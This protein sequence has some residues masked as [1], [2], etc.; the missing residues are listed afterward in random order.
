VAG[1]PFFVDGGGENT[2][3]LTFAREDAPTIEEGVKRLGRVVRAAVSERGGAT[4]A[5]PGA[6][7]ARG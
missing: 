6:S 2:M 7:T 5:D 1:A 4:A 3:R